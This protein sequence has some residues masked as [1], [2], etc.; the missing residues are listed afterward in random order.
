[1][2]T[3][4]IASLALGVMLLA[5][6]AAPAQAETVWSITSAHG[7]QH[8][9]PG[10][11]GQFFIQLRNVGDTDSD[12]SA[13]TINDTLP[14]GLTV[15]SL[16]DIPSDVSNGGPMWDCSATTFPATTV[17]CSTTTPILAPFLNAQ[18]RGGAEPLIMNVAVDPSPPAS[19]DNAV[20]VSGGGAS[21]EASAIDHI[22]FS[23][24][25]AS[26]GFVQGSFAG[27]A[28]DAAFPGGIP[29]RQASSHP[30]ELRVDFDMNL[31]LRDDSDA[32]E[33]FTEPEDRVKTLITR[34]PRGFV[35]NPQAVPMCPLVALNISGVADRGND[36]P[37]NSQIGVI[38]LALQN[39]KKVFVDGAF[40]I[41]LYNMEPPSGVVA[42]FAFSFH[43]N[44]V[45]IQA[46]L[47]P[48]DDYSVITKVTSVNSF[49]AMRSTRLTM[50]GVPAD[51]AHDMLRMD[52]N[53]PDLGDTA[54][55]TPSTAPVRPFLTLPAQCDTPAG[56]FGMSADSWQN[57][58][59]FVSATGESIQAEGC[60]D[61]RI[62]F[63][64]KISI[65]PTSHEAASPTGLEIDLHVP[66]KDDTVTN[67]TDLYSQSGKDQA[68]VTPHLKDAVTKLPV[69]MAVNPSAADGLVGCSQADVGLDDN[70]AP[71][72]PDNSKIGT[73]EIESSLV[74]DLLEGSIYQAKQS[75]NPHGSLLGFYTVARGSGLTIKLAAKVVA[76]PD[77]GQLSTIFL[78]NP[79]L[80]FDH[81]RLRF[82]GGQR[83]P[84]VNPPTCGT[85]TAT[86]HFASWNS[87]VPEVDT[88]DSFQ[89]TSGP[90]SK[91]CVGS[92]AER[93]FAPG[94][95]AKSLLPIAGAFSQFALE[96]SRED[97]MQELRD[98]E[99]TMPPGMT[100]KLAGIPYCP[101]ASIAAVSAAAGS[102][103]GERLSP[104]CPAASLV[105]HSDAAAG[106]GSLPFHNPGNVYLAG[107]Y[108]GA[109]LSLA[110]VTPVVAGPLDLGS[111]VVRAALHV[112]PNTA[113]IRVV[114]DPIPD[115]LRVEGNGFPLNVRS[116][117]VAMDRPE[118]TLNPTS[119]EEMAVGATLASLQGA[120][121]SLAERFQVGACAA[122]GFKPSLKLRLKGQTKRAGY[123]SLRAVL[124]MPG[125]GANIERA[126]VALSP[127]Q[128]LAQEHIANVCT[129]AQFAADACPRESIYGKAVA[130][131]PLLDAP[132]R[133]PVYLKSS[134]NKLPDLVAALRGQVDIDL[135][136]R[137]DTNKRDAIRSSFD[138]V[139]DV[140]VSRFVLNMRGGRY[141]L[142][143]NSAN[144]CRGKPKRGFAAFD[145]HNGR[146]SDF[147]PKITASC[148]KKK[149]KGRN[150]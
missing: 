105:G 113:Q 86:A 110:I 20:T 14:P 109:P 64:P 35:G 100:G 53:D 23:A 107:P 36:C 135:T 27:D 1:M 16:A 140:P 97:G 145:A 67:A 124:N 69:G 45:L 2:R 127:N 22:V 78:G 94:F 79:Q 61:P 18:L 98:L 150:G 70:D 139:P 144:L 84:L 38:D 60:D 17:T 62:R 120:V 99:A 12:G 143:V 8:L 106:A 82:N 47:D 81:Y 42:A 114:S 19:G 146:I 87:S 59:T 122:L 9:P 57:P 41:P 50:W 123:P 131:S 93:P 76:D 54:M 30:F 40:T 26:F 74:P 43:G 66:Q 58:G 137:I 6:A 103:L 148:G 77:T 85:H 138:L 33:L 149:A 21:T 111:I 51:P 31:R 134:S 130:F 71:A 95:D 115:M 28:F 128:F 68:I 34:L 147:R 126:A 101:E 89:L 10:G 75:E 108:K 118:F 104:S 129:R 44:P 37:P 136:G 4:T 125:G 90:N 56:S 11:V 3:R 29:M 72:C 46:E 32:A 73:V 88:G 121:S 142:I 133:G 48:T 13:V 24:T 55:N 117:R 116:V 52:P 15:Q 132:L 63:E 83:A 80:P 96:V 102:G 5:V 119:C 141:G 25:P 65:Q 92:L 39:G 91:P 49:F 7:P 112:D